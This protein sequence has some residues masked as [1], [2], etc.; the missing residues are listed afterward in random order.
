PLS[1]IQRQVGG[2]TNTQLLF[3]KIAV[4]CVHYGIAVDIGIEIRPLLPLGGLNDALIGRVHDAVAVRVPQE[5]IEVPLRFVG[6]IGV[7]VTWGVVVAVAGCP[8]SISADAVGSEID[9]DAIT[10][11][12]EL[13]TQA[14]VDWVDSSQREPREMEAPFGN[15]LT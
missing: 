13:A 3:Y 14:H 7:R 4:G 8:V 10:G 5:P 12:L 9:G 2:Q 6:S 15:E 11:E 1:V